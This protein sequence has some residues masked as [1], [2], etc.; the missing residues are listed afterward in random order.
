MFSATTGIS[1]TMGRSR[2]QISNV[3]SFKV[4]FLATLSALQREGKGREVLQPMVVIGTLALGVTTL[5]V[6]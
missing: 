3:S 6:C 5:F 2:A 1:A 4:S